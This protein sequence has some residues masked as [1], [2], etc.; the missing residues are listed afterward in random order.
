MRGVDALSRR[1]HERNLPEFLA[2]Q[3]NASL[4]TALCDAKLLAF[5]Q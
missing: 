4:Q 3:R 5:D 2:Q 1:C